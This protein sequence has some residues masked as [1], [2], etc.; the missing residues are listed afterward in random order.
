[1]NT[2]CFADKKGSEIMEDMSMEEVQKAFEATVY[3]RFCPRC[4]KPIPYSGNGRPRVYCSNRCRWAC[5][6]ADERRRKLKEHSE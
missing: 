2:L 1:M 3:R 6:K 4:G 5:N